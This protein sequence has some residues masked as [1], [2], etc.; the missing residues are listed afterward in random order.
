MWWEHVFKM[1]F[2]KLLSYY[3]IEVEDILRAQRV[4]DEIYAEHEEAYK[5]DICNGS[6]E[7]KK[8]HVTLNVLHVLKTLVLMHFVNIIKNAYD[9]ICWTSLNVEMLKGTVCWT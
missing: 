3:E 1:R 8:K 4:L 9:K 5:P 7:I 6:I 2:E